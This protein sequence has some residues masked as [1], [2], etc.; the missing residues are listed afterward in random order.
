MIGVKTRALKGIHTYL[1]QHTLHPDPPEIHL[2]SLTLI[3]GH[4]E[5]LHSRWQP[6]LAS[7]QFKII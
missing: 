6:R 4:A 1:G 3:L 5:Q 2:G 7:G